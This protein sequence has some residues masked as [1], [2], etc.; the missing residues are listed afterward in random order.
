[1]IIE[2]MKIQKRRYY[3]DYFVSYDTEN[4][5]NMED[6]KIMNKEQILFL[7]TTYLED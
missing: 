1:M 5:T 2:N 3:K 6:G 7:L 4:T